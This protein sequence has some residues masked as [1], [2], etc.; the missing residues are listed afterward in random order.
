MGEGVDSVTGP[1]SAQLRDYAVNG[2]AA[3]Q[4]KR[5]AEFDELAPQAI[6]ALIERLE[7]RGPELIALARERLLLGFRL[8]PDGP[9]FEWDE[10]QIDQETNEELADSIVYRVQRLVRE[11]NSRPNPA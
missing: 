5:L 10:K 11:S 9:M 2:P 4:P 6:G 1:T 3:S 8:Y 7:T